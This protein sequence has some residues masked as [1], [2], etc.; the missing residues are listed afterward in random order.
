M[1]RVL[2]ALL[3]PLA[4]ASTALADP[5]CGF[6]QYQANIV[7]VHDGDTVRADIDL[8]FNIWRHNEPLRLNGIDAPEL[9]GASK[10]AGILA[11]DA[12]REKVLGKHVTICTIKDRQ[13]KY[14]RYLA[15]IYVD[16]EL[17]NDW[18]ISQGFAKPYFGGKRS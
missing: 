4:F 1:I 14:G 16:D 13:E 11:R 3:G 17:I 10:D 5:A 6:Y 9:R 12:L 7:D 18:M 15:N 2:L 8:G